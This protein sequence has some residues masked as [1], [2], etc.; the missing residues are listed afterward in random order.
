M[1]KELNGVVGTAV[2]RVADCQ[3]IVE[4]IVY[5]ELVGG[6]AHVPEGAGSEV[7]LVL[8]SVCQRV[9]TSIAAALQILI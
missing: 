6:N 4:R 9:A 5:V 2:G 3:S 7:V 8:L 1:V